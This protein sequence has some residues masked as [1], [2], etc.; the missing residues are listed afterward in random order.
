MKI[1][2]VT[3]TKNTGKTTLVEKIVEGLSGEGYHVA[4][5]KHS[6]KSFDFPGRDTDRHRKAGAEIVAGSGRETFI[7]VDREMDFDEI[8]AAIDILDSVDFIVVEGFE[9]MEYANISTSTP[10][11]F[12]VKVVDPFKLEDVDELIAIIKKRSYGLLQGLD[13]GK[14][15]FESCREFAAAKV[16][17]DADEVDCRSQPDRALLKINGKPVPLNPFV[18]NFVSKAVLGMVDALDTE[19]LK[20]E[21]VDLIIKCQRNR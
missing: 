8:I 2:G 20:I 14:C 12:T 1:V 5:L 10:N 21:K 7:L 11:E 6:H 19:N 4:T 9:S 13:C 16:R 17:G 15:G 3:G 18:Q